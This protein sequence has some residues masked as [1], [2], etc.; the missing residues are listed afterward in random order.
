M[1]VV[2]NRIVTSPANYYI[3]DR[4]PS[5]TDHRAVFTSSINPYYTDLLTN[6]DS[7]SGMHLNVF[8]WSWHPGAEFRR[9]GTSSR[10]EKRERESRGL[11]RQ[12]KHGKMSLPSTW[13]HF[14]LTE[15]YT[16]NNM[17]GTHRFNSGHRTFLFPVHR[18]KVSIMVS[19][20]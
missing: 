19:K 7:D 10:L 18:I 3:K 17:A 13:S 5:T 2:A 15:D 11:P 1:K 16:E 12:E 14:P 9:G 4:Q 8:F 6:I 20:H